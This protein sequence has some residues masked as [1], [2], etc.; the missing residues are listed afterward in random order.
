MSKK[1]DNKIENFTREMDSSHTEFRNLVM[2][3]TKDWMWQKN[4][5]LQANKNDRQESMRH[6]GCAAKV[7]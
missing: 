2:G 4:W 5:K 7:V 6:M 1:I 3:I